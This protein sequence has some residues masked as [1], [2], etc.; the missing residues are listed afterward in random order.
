MRIAVIDGQGGGLGRSIVEALRRALS[1]DI[2][3]IALG[4]NAIATAAML[5]AGADAGAT[6]ENAITVT[7]SSCDIIVGPLGIVAANSMFG[8][9]TPAMALAVAA[10]PAQKFLLPTTRC[11]LNVV[12]YP[13]KSLS[14]TLESLVV[15]IQE[16]LAQA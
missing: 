3:I 13:S 1:P 12:G 10:S 2:E 11:N 7:C 9:L 15:E 16:F 8:E 4:T 6:G 14:A 5:K